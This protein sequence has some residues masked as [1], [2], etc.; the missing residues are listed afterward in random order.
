MNNLNYENVFLYNISH[1]DYYNE[2]MD[3]LFNN[4]NSLTCKTSFFVLL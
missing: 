4:Y 3:K 2:L 1:I